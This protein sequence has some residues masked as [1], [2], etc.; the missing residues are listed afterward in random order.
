MPLA[1]LIRL[2]GERVYRPMYHTVRGDYPLPHIEHL[3]TPHTAERF[4]RDLDTLLQRFDPIGLD[5]LPTALSGER[6]GRR[7]ALLLT[8]D[9]GL[10]EVHDVAL[11]VLRAKGVPAIVFVNSAFVGNRA[12][13]FRYLASALIAH[14]EMRPPS[15]RLA[16]ELVDTLRGTESGTGGGRNIDWRRALLDMRYADRHRLDAAALLLEFDTH[17]FLARQ[18]PYLSLEELERLRTEGF[19]IGAHSVDHPLYR[20]LELDEQLAQTRASC[21]YV[22]RTFAQSDCTFAFP[23]SDVGVHGAFFERVRDEGIASTLFGGQGYRL[24]SFPA[25]VQRHS[26]EGREGSVEQLLR[27]DHVMSLARRVSGRYRV[28]RG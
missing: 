6:H 18:R 25:M 15:D 24:E 5:E 9:D 1:W 26:M 12:L 16:G 2:S 10:R 7:P 17:A 20:E 13:F 3:Y 22:R 4:A 27:A 23:F 21:D 28:R 19:A 14:A 11:P 8:F